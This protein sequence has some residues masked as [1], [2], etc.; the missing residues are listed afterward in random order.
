MS[1]V[2]CRIKEDCIEVASDS[3]IVFG[4]T[5][6]KGKDKFSKLIEVN[7]IIIGSVGSAA[8]CSMLQIFANTRKPSSSTEKG[9]LEFMVEFAEWKKGKTDKYEIENNF[10]IVFEKH[11]FQINSFFVKEIEKYDAIGAGMDY[12]LA[13][14]YLGHDV[15]TAVEVACEL[16]I[17]CEKPV[18]KLVS[19]K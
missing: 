10:I 7:N 16:S 5:Q 9:I 11:V 17:Y 3:I 8:E 15:E 2:C 19:P 6:D 18:K 14:L 4:S 1:V 13:A 12:A